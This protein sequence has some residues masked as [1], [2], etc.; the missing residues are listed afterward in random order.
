MKNPNFQIVLFLFCSLCVYIGEYINKILSQGLWEA[1]STQNYFDPRG[2][3][4]MM[5]FSGPLIFLLTF[6]LGNMI[7]QSMQML[8]ILK[9]AQLA[10]KRKKEKQN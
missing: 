2:V 3:F 6:L 5:M 8:V 4:A 10:E 7:Y 1:I 9:R